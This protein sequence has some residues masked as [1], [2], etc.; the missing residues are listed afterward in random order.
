MIFQ[1]H[2]MTLQ[3]SEPGRLVVFESGVTAEPAMRP[4]ELM[5]NVALRAPFPML[6]HVRRVLEGELRKHTLFKAGS[7]LAHITNQRP[8]GSYVVAGSISIL[9]V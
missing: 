8:D 6:R 2:M 1:L 9:S 7:G 3:D 4:A 5:H